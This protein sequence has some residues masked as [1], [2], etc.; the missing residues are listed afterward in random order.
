LTDA[1]RPSERRRAARV[2]VEIRA[3]VEVLGARPA[4]FDPDYECL[5]IPNDLAGQRFSATIV[6]LSMNGARLTSTVIP[7]LMS[8]ISLFFEVPGHGSTL[9]ACLVMWRRATPS[10]PPPSGDWR[11]EASHL[12][13]FGVLFEAL[14]ISARQAIGQLASR[15]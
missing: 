6:D 11:G 13:G 10:A 7:A 12:P 1:M 9:G 8:R 5:T 14:D 4:R 15:P 3:T 2:Q